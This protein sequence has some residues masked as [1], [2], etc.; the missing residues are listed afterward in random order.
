MLT[1]ERHFFVPREAE[2]LRDMADE[3]SAKPREIEAGT[4]TE[5]VQLPKVSFVWRALQP[6]WLLGMVA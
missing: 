3:A 5:N 4:S 2:L 1:A 6:G